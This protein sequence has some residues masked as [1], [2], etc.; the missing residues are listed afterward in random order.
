MKNTCI[1]S[2]LIVLIIGCSTKSRKQEEIKNLHIKD[3]L[4][5]V[6]QQDSIQKAK[7]EKEKQILLDSINKEREKVAIAD[8]NFGINH[9]NYKV[10]EKN[11]LKSCQYEGGGLYYLGGFRFNME[12]IFNSNDS[13]YCIILKGNKQSISDYGKQEVKRDYNLLYSI[14]KEKY[15]SPNVNYG[16]PDMHEE[17]SFM[18]EHSTS[19]SYGKYGED[20]YQTYHYC[21]CAKWEIGR[22]IIEIRLK[23]YYKKVISVILVIY[24]DDITTRVENENH[25]LYQI[26]KQKMDN[27]EKVDLKKAIDLL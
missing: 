4:K 12:G 6:S 3:S 17:S 22:K 8:I 13:L 23:W 14:L 25:Q 5:L 2:L 18:W 11:F 1:I 21:E 10:K 9:F 20:S 7:L 27:K 24:R 19:A 16:I 15:S 26:E